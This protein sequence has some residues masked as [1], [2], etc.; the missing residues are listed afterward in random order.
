MTDDDDNEQPNLISKFTNLFTSSFVTS[1]KSP[2]PTSQPDNQF[3][4]FSWIKKAGL[5]RY[6]NLQFEIESATRSQFWTQWRWFARTVIV[7]TAKLTQILNG[8]SSTL[9]IEVLGNVKLYWYNTR[10]VMFTD[11]TPSQQEM[12]DNHLKKDIKNKQNKLEE[13]VFHHLPLTCFAF[14]KAN[15][16]TG[17]FAITINNCDNN[18]WYS[19]M[20][21]YKLNDT[22]SK[23]DK[24]KHANAELDDMISREPKS[25]CAVRSK[26]MLEL[27]YCVENT[28][29][30]ADL[31]NFRNSLATVTFDNQFCPKWENII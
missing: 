27:I 24:L 29:Y 17:M 30:Y 25:F 12:L 5:Q 20:L 1:N 10:W 31:S 13:R 9:E 26:D 3:V 23:E 2:Q 16:K 14:D 15:V 7:G 19:N 18:R 28:N 4:S 8:Q 11:F 22:I 6:N 21:S